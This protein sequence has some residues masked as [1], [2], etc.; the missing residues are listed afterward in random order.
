[1][2]IIAYLPLIQ[3]L[4]AD[5]LTRKRHDEGKAPLNV[6]GI[7]LI[8]VSFLLAIPGIIFAL[9]SLQ[10]WLA[11]IY[12]TS[13]S[14]LITSAVCLVASCFVALCGNL[15]QAAD[16]ERKAIAPATRTG[17]DKQP[18]SIIKGLIDDLA[19]PVREHPLASVLVAGLAGLMAGEV[20]K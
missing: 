12:D 8:A 6:K 20:K 14:W 13:L 5:N 19:V 4:V 2:S 7:G 3:Q 15:M 11:T 9:L 1:M 17:S 18:D 16:D 10:T